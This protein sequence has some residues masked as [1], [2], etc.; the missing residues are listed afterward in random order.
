M[1]LVGACYGNLGSAHYSSEQFHE[2]LRDYQQQFEMAK[3]L[4]DRILEARSL[5]NKGRV[6]QS[7][8]QCRRSISDQERALHIFKVVADRAGQA[9]CYMHLGE[10][11]YKL[12]ELEQSATYLRNAEDLLRESKQPHLLEALYGSLAEVYS[13]MG[14]T[15]SALDVLR[16]QE[17]LLMEESHG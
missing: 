12:K 3:A 14:D 8:G 15:T 13:A 2:A 17:A 11:C 5:S 7:L 1:P 16:K 4:G 10:S 9:L 6:L